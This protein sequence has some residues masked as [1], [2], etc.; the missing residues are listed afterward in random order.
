[1]Q[2]HTHR[3]R[4]THRFTDNGTHTQVHTEM[5]TQR[6]CTHKHTDT[7]V[8]TMCRHTATQRDTHRH[9]CTCTHPCAHRMHREEGLAKGKTP[10][11][12]VELPH[13]AGDTLGAVAVLLGVAVL[14]A[15]DSSVQLP[16]TKLFPA[17]ALPPRSRPWSRN[18]GRDRGCL[19]QGVGF[20]ST[21]GS[22]GW[23]L[24]R[25]WGGKQ[26]G[27]PLPPSSM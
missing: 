26:T 8:H 27:S 20:N 19:P 5:Y 14:P 21:K 2:V 4:Y 1:M 23:W 13:R 17:P 10:G 16:V 11:A 18:V 15:G 7:H 25:F 9:I 6:M 12:A 3:H 22:Q 24:C